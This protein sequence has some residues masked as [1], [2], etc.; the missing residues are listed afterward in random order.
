MNSPLLQWVRKLFLL[1]NGL[2]FLGF[3]IATTVN[4][5]WTATLY[6]YTLNGVGGANEFR[7]VY[8]GFWLGLTY[9]F[10]RALKHYNLAILGDVMFTLVFM[11]SL[12]RLYSFAVDG[13]PPLQ[14]V[15]FF[16]LEFVTA[17][18]GLL[19]RPHAQAEAAT[20]RTAALA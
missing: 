12:G 19:I 5:T 6:G 11:Q 10:F 17:G 15:L 13:I 9:G 18:I 3:A 1:G 16:V 4:L 8:M 20:V 2:T 14:F 7:A